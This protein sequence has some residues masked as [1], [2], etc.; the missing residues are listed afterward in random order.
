[1][2]EKRTDR[3]WA[4]HL[5][6]RFAR[7]VAIAMIAVGFVLNVWLILIGA[8]VYFASSAEEKTARIHQ[9]V[10]DRHV[11][12]VMIRDPICAPPDES[13]EQLLR[14]MSTTAQRDFP[15]VAADGAYLGLVRAGV[16]LHAAPDARVRSAADSIPPLAPDDPLETSD[17]LDGEISAAAVVTE[18]RV[19][20]LV[21]AADAAL[22]TR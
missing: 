19:V 13:V 5:A 17:L 14:V 10:M 15:V 16:L 18:G 12:D 9:R 3:D 21:R 20:G 1:M 11:S 6:A 2:F 4:T 7:V 8:L 22:P